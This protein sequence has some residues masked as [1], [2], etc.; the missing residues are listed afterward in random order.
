MALSGGSTT[1]RKPQKRETLWLPFA[2]RP[3]SRAAF[4]PNSI[5]RVFSGCSSRP[6]FASRF[7]NSLRNRL[8]SADRPFSADKFTV[9]LV[10]GNCPGA[11]VRADLSAVVPVRLRIRPPHPVPSR[12]SLTFQ[13]VIAVPQQIHGQ[14]VQQRSEPFLLPFPC[15]FPHAPQTLCRGCSVLCRN[16]A[17]LT[18]V[19]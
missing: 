1:M 11:P 3:H 13:R 12:C 14:M 8:A 17:C 15:C 10:P 2:P 18:D 9:T 16:R 6:N 5:N 19:L 4:G 7:P